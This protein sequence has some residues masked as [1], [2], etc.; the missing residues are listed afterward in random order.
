MAELAFEL[1]R[2]HA[3]PFAYTAHSLV[4]LELGAR[5]GEWVEVQQRVFEAADV[6]IFVSRSERDAAVSRMPSLASRAHVLHNG[7]SP[8]P[9]LTAYDPNGPVVFAG[10]FARTKGFDLLL[11]LIPS[12]EAE[13][14]LAGGH[15]ER[16]LHERALALASAGRCRIAGWLAR[17]ELEALFARASLV[18]MPSRYEPFGMVALEAMRMGAPLLASCA[19]GLAEIVVP[20]SGGAC[21]PEPTVAA[22]NAACARLLADERERT[23]MHERGPRHIAAHFDARALAAQAFRL[24]HNR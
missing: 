6:V 4:E 10:R 14:V 15:G 7:V 5:A 22:W 8:P 11:E 18:L 12:I 17:A 2:R 24:L 9:P 23:A 3:L 21:V 20:E 13:V 19:G 1:V 16:V